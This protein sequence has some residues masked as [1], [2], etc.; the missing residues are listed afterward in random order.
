[1][2]KAKHAFKVIS[3]M[4]ALLEGKI[5]ELGNVHYKLMHDGDSF[6]FHYT[7]DG[8]SNFTKRTYIDFEFFTKLCGHLT[9]EEV[10]EINIK[11]L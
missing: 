6:E 11:D 10:M 1:M 4:K 2:T 3:V 9:E 5:V 7:I 8:K